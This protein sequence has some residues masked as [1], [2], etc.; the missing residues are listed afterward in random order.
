MG[1]WAGVFADLGWGQFGGEGEFGCGGGGKVMGAGGGGGGGGKVGVV[2]WDGYW[3]F[4]SLAVH[5][6][7]L[8]CHADV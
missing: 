1:V 6:S 2:G 8:E 3:C 5:C 4:W 7:R